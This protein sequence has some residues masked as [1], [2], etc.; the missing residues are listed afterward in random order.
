MLESSHTIQG[1]SLIV[2]RFC[3]DK[4]LLDK[5]NGPI[6][7]HHIPKTAGTSLTL[8][9]IDLFGDQMLNVRSELKLNNYSADI[10]HYK[11]VSGHFSPEKLNE[12]FPVRNQFSILRDPVARNISQ[13]KDWSS[14]EKIE[15]D[16]DTW[17]LDQKHQ[18]AFRIG[19]K[20]S[21]LEFL[22]SDNEIIALNTRNIL[23][24]ALSGVRDVD[25]FS[26][27]RGLV[28]AALHNLE[29]MLWFG[30]S[31]DYQRSVE[32]LWFQLGAPLSTELLSSVH[33]V[34]TKQVSPPSRETLAQIKRINALDVELYRGAKAIYERRR[35]LFEREAAHRA[36]YWESR[37]R[38]IYERC[39]Q[40]ILADEPSLGVGFGYRE[41]NSEGKPFRW[42]EGPGPSVIHAPGIKT[43]ALIRRVTVRISLIAA[44]DP[45][46]QESLQCYFANWSAISRTSH[47]SDDG[48]VIEYVFDI[49][50]AALGD[51]IK[52]TLFQKFKAVIN[53]RNEPRS[54]GVAI[55]RIQIEYLMES[56]A[57][58]T[59]ID[60]G[61]A[62]KTVETRSWL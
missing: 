22:S 42:T 26:T 28:D 34:S 13:Y 30:I 6:V 36:I 29:Q 24:R 45:E 8:A 47:Q 58:T 14:P 25:P 15:Q 37:S 12:T 51:T 3:D 46:A 38:Q 11:C 55:H 16:P 41:Q 9:L 27:D 7:F 19:Q 54:P 33:N 31:E 59:S 43:V 2:S 49:A 62:A 21:L 17:L 48:V 44:V 60:R 10:Y 52:L 53:N 20:S 35:R 39:R 57:Q 18:E 5:C 23:T 1:A 56:S 50:G 40:E 32:M 61:S 4:L